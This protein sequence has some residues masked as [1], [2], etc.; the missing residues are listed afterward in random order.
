MDLEH[1]RAALPGAA[2]FYCETIVNPTTAIPDLAALAELCRGRIDALY[3]LAAESGGGRAR[4][5][6]EKHTL[7]SAALTSELYP[8][9]R[10]VFLVRDFRDMVTSILA[11]NRKRGVRGFGEGAADGAVDYVGRLGGWAQGLVRSYSRRAG[12][13]HVLRYEEL[14]AEPRAALTGLLEYLGVDARNAAVARMLEA[15]GTEMPELARHATSASPD[16]SIG[17]WRSELDEDLRRACEQSFG[18]A[19]ATFGYE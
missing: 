11:F 7:R 13:A 17:R 10:E 6:A 9:A 15:L 14:V 5:F 2:L 4:Y 1:V 19:L 16:A 12:R 18:E 8:H 3:R